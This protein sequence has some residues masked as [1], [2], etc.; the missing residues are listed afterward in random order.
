MKKALLLVAGLS[1]FFP[2]TASTTLVTTGTMNITWSAPEVWVDFG[3]SFYS[4]YSRYNSDA[5]TTSLTINTDLQL[6]ST[7]A[8][9]VD[10]EVYKNGQSYE[11]YTIDSIELSAN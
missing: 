7:E 5:D 4:K 10:Q 1:F 8:F 9:C 2:M 6:K 11:F 3:N